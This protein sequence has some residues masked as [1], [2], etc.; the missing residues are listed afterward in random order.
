[1][2]KKK[3]V[4]LGLTA[5]ASHAMAA[6]L[7]AT[8]V[9]RSPQAIETAVNLAGGK[10]EVKTEGDIASGSILNLTYSTAPT[11]PAA[12]DVVLKAGQT[13]CDPDNDSI[14]YS[15][16]SNS[17]KTLNYTLVDKT[18]QPLQ[19]DCIIV[20]G[21]VTAPSFP[22]ASVTTTGVTVSSGFTV[23]GTG[24]DPSQAAAT[25]RVVLALGK[26]QYKQ[27]IVGADAV[28]NVSAIP[29]RTTFTGTDTADKITITLG[30]TGEGAN[31]GA[32][33]T[34]ITGDFSWADDASKAGF[35]LI[36]GAIAL[37][38]VG[39][40]DVSIGTGAD[41]P[42]ATTYTI[43][44]ASPKDT[45]TYTIT[46]TP[47]KDLLAVPIPTGAFSAT[48]TFAYTDLASSTG[49]AAVTTAA[50]AFTLN[51]ATVKVFSV[52]FGPEVESHSIF[53]SNSGTA[54]GAVT[55][56]M[57]W[58]GN[59]AVEFS[60]GDVQ[61]KANKYLNVMGALEALGEKP[62]FG[63]ADLT[64][65]VNAPAAAITMTAAYNTAEGRANLFMAEQANIASIS[66]AAKTSAAANTTALA[67]IDGEI[68]TIDTVVDTTNSVVDTTCAN[69]ANGS[70]KD[71]DSTTNANTAFKK[72][73]CP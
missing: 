49:S 35:Q 7:T 24:V 10:V 63:R 46:L 17:G 20:V 39:D 21:G 9:T 57:V 43:V 1:M 32:S 45:N 73:A 52:P 5:I 64:F 41:A 33:K 47:Q 59:D 37:A 50:G 42:T 62:P 29:T 34:V 66:N 44:D 48:T 12:V 53:V 25:K 65:T 51:G 27:T 68:E 18:A 69:L 31:T 38:E 3:L 15:G 11:N 54:T 36:D 19:K 56:S 67:T 22:K 13:K 8:K 28:V 58:N 40:A 61:A 14:A 72:T 23:V 60:L 6:D 26:T 30:D 2:F 4:A 70:I 55:G 71:A 16:S